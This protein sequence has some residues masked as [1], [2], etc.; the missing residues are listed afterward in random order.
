V[1]GP[2]LTHL[3]G[4]TVLLE[5]GGW[6]IL[7]DPTFDPPGRTYRFGWGTS[8]RKL[9]GPTCDPSDL[10]PI[11]LVLVSHDHHA[12]NLDD[13]GRALLPSAGAVV[14]TRPA[15]RRLGG[16]VR[17]MAAWD[18]TVVDAPGRPS[19]TVTATP[20]RHGPP[21][22]HPIV[23]EVVGFAL[24][25]E[26]RDGT[27]WFSGDT[28][29]Y[30]GVRAVASRCDV[31]VA[32]VHLGEVRFPVT[33]PV[34]YSMTAHDALELCSLLQPRVMVPVHYEGWSHF[35]EGPESVRSAIAAAPA[36]LRS[37]VRM[38]PRGVVVDLADHGR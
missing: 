35:H 1:T 12:D 3:G 36:E 30:D 2:R 7:S 38:V 10:G 21:L 4:P 24:D 17:G 33:G 11:D 29:L 18:R 32:V 23:G 9:T 27:I 13:A 16:D 6:R 15:A 25:V 37:R 22:S 31:D 28:V 8:S 20:C 14:S 5:V 26:G 19:I 34:S